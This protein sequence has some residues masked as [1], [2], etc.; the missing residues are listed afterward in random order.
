MTL[1]ECYEALG[2]N[3][4]EAVARLMNEDFATRMVKKFADKNTFAE[5]ESAM[6]DRDLTKAFEAAHTMKGN[7]LNLSFDRLAGSVS[8]FS[9]ILKSGTFDGTDEVF[10]RVRDDFDATIAAIRQLD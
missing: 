8:E 4:D 9:D 10:T 2:G 3:Y 1:K 5:M 6:A 7:V